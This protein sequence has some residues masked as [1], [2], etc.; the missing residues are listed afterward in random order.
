MTPP[1][2]KES[3]EYFVKFMARTLII[4]S[5]LVHTQVLPTFKTSTS[6]E[7]GYTVGSGALLPVHRISLESA[8][9]AQ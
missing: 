5:K 3:S 8:E 2:S 9:G 7:Q 6:G 4:F 1:Q